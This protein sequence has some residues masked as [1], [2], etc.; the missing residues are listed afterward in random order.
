MRMLEVHRNRVY[1]L[2]PEEEALR[3][4]LETLHQELNKPTVFEGRIRELE[5][6]VDVQKSMRGSRSN[7]EAFN[8]TDET[9]LAAIS[10]VRCGIFCF[11]CSSHMFGFV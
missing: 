10:S 7:E 8:I 9:A 1:V 6:F 3:L 11:G 4:Q 2:Q 5:A